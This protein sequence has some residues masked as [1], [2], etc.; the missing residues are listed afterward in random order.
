MVVTIILDKVIVLTAIV[1]IVILEA[2]A[3]SKGINGVLLTTV[4]ALIAGISGYEFRLYL[5]GGRNAIENILDK[6]L[7]E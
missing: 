4:I 1:G 2:I 3:L 6:E 5:T 7:M